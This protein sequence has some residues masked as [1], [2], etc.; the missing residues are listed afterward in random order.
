MQGKK[1]LAGKTIKDFAQFICQAFAAR[2]LGPN[3]DKGSDPKCK[4]A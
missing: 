4:L 3:K 2:N 1:C